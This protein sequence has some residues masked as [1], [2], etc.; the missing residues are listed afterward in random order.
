M[1]DLPV[2]LLPPADGRSPLGQPKA[3]GGRLS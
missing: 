2:F 1:G 3:V